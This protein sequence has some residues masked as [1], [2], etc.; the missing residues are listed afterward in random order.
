MNAV[1]TDDWINFAN[2]QAISD[3]LCVPLRTVQ[4]WCAKQRMPR[5]Y[6][7]LYR[8][9]TRGDLGELWPAWRGWRVVGDTLITTDGIVLKLKEVSALPFTQM[10][11]FEH[12][13]MER[14]AAEQQ[15]VPLLLQRNGHDLEEEQ[16]P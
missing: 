15:S 7:R 5:G 13:R 2:P 6:A 10:A 16:Q 1:T 8:L 11:L 4:R 12:R 14:I 3:M 9:L